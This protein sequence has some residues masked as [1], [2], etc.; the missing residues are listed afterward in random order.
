MMLDLL[1]DVMILADQKV[2]TSGMRMSGEEIHDCD[3]C[4]EV[5]PDVDLWAEDSETGE[6][7]W[8]CQA[9]GDW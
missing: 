5:K 9:C 4:G 6:G 1:D 7:L 3:G 8:L 2:T